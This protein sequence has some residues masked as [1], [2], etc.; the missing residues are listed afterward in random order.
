MELLLIEL[1]PLAAV[2]ALSPLCYLVLHVI[3]K[4]FTT[5]R[6]TK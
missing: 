1:H 5:P 6:S 4:T 2:A 3:V